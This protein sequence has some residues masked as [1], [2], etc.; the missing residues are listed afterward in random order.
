ME[1]TDAFGRAMYD[2]YRGKSLCEIIERDDGYIDASAIDTLYFAEYRDWPV[3]ERRAIQLA[4]GKVLDIGC[5]AGRAALYLQKKGL[6]V[7]GIDVSPLVLKVCRL[8]GLRKTKLLSIT[9]LTRRL[10]V[11]DTLLMYGNNF[12]L[13]GNSTRARWLLRRFHRM[14]TPDARIIA[15]T[16]DPYQTKERHHR[17]YHERNR[18]RGRMPGQVRIRERY[19]RDATPYF[20]YLFVSRKELAAILDG[21]G[22]HI[23]RIFASHGPI[24]VAVLEKTA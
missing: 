18:R 13:V 11:F 24:Y 21:T 7:L 9:Q 14:T 3:Y 16:L 20:D 5:G 23:A 12:G 8:R 2:R 10:G 6:N 22:W 1:H 17:D 19:Q 4:R 15:E